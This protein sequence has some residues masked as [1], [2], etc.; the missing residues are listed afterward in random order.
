MQS[1]I[2][3]N[4]KERNPFLRYY[5]TLFIIVGIVAGI[6]IGYF[7]SKGVLKTEQDNFDYGKM[8]LLSS[9]ISVAS[10]LSSVGTS[11]LANKITL[12]IKQNKKPL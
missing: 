6:I 12:K 1:T 9:L 7:V 4:G 5:L 11:I 8:I 10:L 3:R 2:Y